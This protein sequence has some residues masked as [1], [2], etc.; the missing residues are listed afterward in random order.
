MCN[1]EV[2]DGLS[3]PNTL[4]AENENVWNMFYPNALLSGKLL[5]ALSPGGMTRT[6]VIRTPHGN[7]TTSMLV[8]YGSWNTHNNL[9][10]RHS[11]DALNPERFTVKG[12]SH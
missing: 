6:S 11:A 10:F 8:N 7:R 12:H 4:C 9:Q 2:M 5:C 3:P 1:N